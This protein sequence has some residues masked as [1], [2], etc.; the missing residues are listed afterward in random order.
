MNQN[1]K[2]LFETFACSLKALALS[3]SICDIILT[4]EQ[5]KQ[6]PDLYRKHA[7]ELCRKYCLR[8]GVPPEELLKNVSQNPFD[9][10]VSSHS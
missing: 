2:L 4:D 8:L 1:D 10:S 6:I 3:S 9:D 5:R 7:M